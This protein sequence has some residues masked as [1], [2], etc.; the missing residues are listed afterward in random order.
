MKRFLKWPWGRISCAVGAIVST[1]TAS[2]HP[3]GAIPSLAIF[4]FGGLIL[5]GLATWRD[6]P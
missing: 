2:S 5:Q 3:A 6:K 1:L 4:V